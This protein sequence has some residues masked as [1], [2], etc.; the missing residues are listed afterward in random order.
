MN[1]HNMDAENKPIWVKDS[2][3]DFIDNRLLYQPEAERFVLGAILLDNDVIAEITLAPRDFCKP[4]YGAIFSQ[5]LNLYTS[6]T[7]IDIWYL[8]QQMDGRVGAEE[9]GDIM[10]SCPTAANIKIHARMVAECAR[11]RRII[12]A[13]E[14]GKDEALTEDDIDKLA[15]TVERE[16]FRATRSEGGKAGIL[17]LDNILVSVGE[18]IGAVQ[19]GDDSRVP[20]GYTD[21]DSC[22]GGYEPGSLYI[23][24]ARPSMGKTAL[25]LSMI[26]NVA[27]R[28]LSVAFFSLEMSCR[29]VGQ[30]LLSAKS[31]FSFGHII[32][33]G[34]RTKIDAAMEDLKGLKVGVDDRGKL[35][36]TQI[37]SELRRFKMK[38]GLD[39]VF[40]D[41]LQLMRGEG[42]NR[43]QEIGDITSG[44]KNIAKEFDVPVVALSQL[45]RE[46]EKRSD[47][48]PMLSDLRD[49]GTI[50]QDADVVM[51][52]YR[53]D[54]YT[55]EDTGT[56]EVI[57]AKNRNGR[58]GK[59]NLVW[60][61]EIM[62]FEN[63]AF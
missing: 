27:E 56:A 44:L 14:G 37:T 19:R 40:V 46:A 7:D 17:G 22:L 1:L 54:Y 26:Q 31:G 59:V 18:Y 43:V 35:S 33:R 23:I 2:I 47:K 25:A 11:R 4:L 38:H 10:D 57:I 8:N 51:L 53:E 48:H 39:I 15:D 9:L 21:I 36:C 28:D 5:M 63:G 50:E 49:S 34:D 61:P 20:S 12:S 16:V 55:R 45:S 62:R 32:H 6:N 24:A 58:T 30:R 41:Y 13:C 3:K 29:Q 42:Q 60:L 52:L